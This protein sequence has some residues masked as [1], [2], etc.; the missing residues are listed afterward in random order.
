MFG[1]LNSTRS[2][3]VAFL[4]LLLFGILIWGIVISYLSEAHFPSFICYFC[5]LRPF[6]NR[7][8][9]HCYLTIGI[10]I[11]GKWMWIIQKSLKRRLRWSLCKKWGFF[12]VVAVKSFRAG[13]ENS[14]ESVVYQEELILVLMSWNC[15]TNEW[16]AG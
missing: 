9:F 5:V 10:R 11:F 8:Y 12:E 3:A 2:I 7:F 1:Q 15:N 14:Q 4:L 16:S 6:T 13:T